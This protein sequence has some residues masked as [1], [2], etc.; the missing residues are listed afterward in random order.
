MLLSML[1]GCGY[2]RW[3][4]PGSQPGDFQRD[5]EA[6]QREAAA[7]QWEACMTGRGWHFVST[8]Y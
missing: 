7:G 2:D 3:Q 4:K 6:C 8:W 5:N 1:A